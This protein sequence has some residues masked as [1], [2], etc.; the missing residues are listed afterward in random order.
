MLEKCSRNAFEILDSSTTTIGE[1]SP[2]LH[3][4]P[5]LFFHIL[6]ADFFPIKV[7]QMSSEPKRLGDRTQTYFC[8][9]IPFQVHRPFFFRVLRRRDSRG[10]GRYRVGAGGDHQAHAQQAAN[11]RGEEGSAWGKGHEESLARLHTTTIKKH[12]LKK[13]RLKFL[14]SHNPRGNTV[15]TLK[16]K[17]VS[18]I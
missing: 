17:S 13:T 5:L 10:E 9:F 6:S 8:P 1:F 7:P 11:D 2:R 4:F 18:H 12:R 3:D 16:S 14:I 15:I